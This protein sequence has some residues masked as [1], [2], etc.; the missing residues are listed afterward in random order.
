MRGEDSR[1][2]ATK[3]STGKLGLTR[4]WY[5]SYKADVLSSV[6]ATSNLYLL[7][8]HIVSLYHVLTYRRVPSKL[9]QTSMFDRA[10]AL[11]NIVKTL[12][13]SLCTP[14]RMTNTSEAIHH[15]HAN[16]GIMNRSIPS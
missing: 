6:T 4:L 8:L 10:G 2:P 16:K 3:H 15:E 9:S 13:Y 14:T 11:G 7:S 1:F 12:D 5:V